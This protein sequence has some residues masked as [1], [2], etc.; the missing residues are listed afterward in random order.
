VG[1]G[2]AKKDMLNQ[3][4]WSGMTIR[5]KVIPLQLGEIDGADDHVASGV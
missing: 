1:T 3:K 2:F 4:S 5:T